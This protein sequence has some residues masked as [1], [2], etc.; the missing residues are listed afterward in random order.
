MQYD[1]E[2]QIWTEQDFDNMGWHDSSIYGIAFGRPYE[3][4]FDIDYIF[5]WVE[6]TAANGSTWLINLYFL[7]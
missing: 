1:L 2:N 5:K 3:L 7:K 4:S 6:P